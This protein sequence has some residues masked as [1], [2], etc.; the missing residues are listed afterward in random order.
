M[1]ITKITNT[2]H[3]SVDEVNWTKLINNIQQLYVKL[4][5]EYP[6]L[7]EFS[8]YAMDQVTQ[9][10]VKEMYEKAEKY[11]F[12]IQNLHRGLHLR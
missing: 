2:T 10:K 5:K 11:W 7:F 3:T 8:T 4:D 9:A 1:Q 12:G 6:Y